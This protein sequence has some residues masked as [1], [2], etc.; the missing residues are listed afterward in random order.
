MLR[1][2][3]AERMVKDDFAVKFTQKMGEIIYDAKTRMGPWATMTETSF[4][5]YGMG[6]L[7]VGHGQ[8]YL[9]QANGE[10]HCIEGGT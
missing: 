2:L 3:S 1:Y 9:R 5:V 7:G 8:K 6:H 10:L 4:K